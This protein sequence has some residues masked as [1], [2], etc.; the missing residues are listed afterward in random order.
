MLTGKEVITK[1]EWDGLVQKFEDHTILQAWSWGE[2]RQAIGEEVYRFAYLDGEYAKGAALVTI[3]KT[4][5][6][7][8]MYVGYGPLVND[9]TQNSYEEVLNHLKAFAKE[10]KCDYLT[11]DPQ[12]L[13]IDENKKKLKSLGF[14]E[15]HRHIQANHK[16]LLDVTKDEETLMMEMRKNTRYSIKKALK[17]GVVI[18]K[19][20]NLEDFQLFQD[21]LEETAKRKK[22][23]THSEK[24][25][26]EF[27]ILGKNDNMLLIWAEFQGK[28]VSAA[29]ISYYGKHAGYLWGATSSGL[30]NNV[31]AAYPVLWEAILEAKRREVTIFDFWGIA[32][33]EAPKNHPWQGFTFFKTGFGGYYKR[34]ILPYDYPITLKY[35]IIKTI[36]KSR[37]IWG[38][39]YKKIRLG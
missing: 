38:G 14:V 28:P 12:L 10:K 15:A 36:S 16:W 37:S 26:K 7:R 6:G 17:D 8:W 24:L 4:K 27:D 25:E 30:P 13:D 22:F 9:W 31:P 18:K 2:F 21:A 1:E 39:L 3:E 33:P 19:S 11:I 23:Y 32:P 29:I 20:A 35:W 34:L 5:Y